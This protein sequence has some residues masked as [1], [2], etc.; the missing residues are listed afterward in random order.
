MNEDIA[1]AMLHLELASELM[2]QS[3][4]V[5]NNLAV[6]MALRDDPD[7][8]MA[9]KISNAAIEQTERPTPH[10]YETRG[11]ILYQLGSFQA[12]IPDLERALAEPN[13]AKKAHEMLAVSYDRVGDRELANAHRAKSKE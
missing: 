11:Q 2:P 12:A 1:N 6:A 3:G 8:E 4:A 9:L 13:L 5:L 7:L 10:F